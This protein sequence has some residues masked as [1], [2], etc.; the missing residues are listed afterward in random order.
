MARTR[1]LGDR[2]RDAGLHSTPWLPAFPF[3]ASATDNTEYCNL[4]AAR[5]LTFGDVKDVLAETRRR[6]HDFSLRHAAERRQA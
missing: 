6:L 3:R 1:Q 4:L 2:R 5:P